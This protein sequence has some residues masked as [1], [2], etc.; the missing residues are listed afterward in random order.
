MVD[1]ALDVALLLE[2][3]DGASGEGTVDLH[4][5][6]EDGL[7]DELVSGDLLD[8]SVA[9]EVIVSTREPRRPNDG[10]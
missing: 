9:A 5:V 6:D 4:T 8:D 2:E 3:S 7:G 1:D 10:M